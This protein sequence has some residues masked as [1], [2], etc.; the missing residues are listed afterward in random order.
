MQTTVA[1]Q[2]KE[3]NSNSPTPFHQPFTTTT[4]CSSVTQLPAE[5]TETMIRQVV[6]ALTQTMS[7]LTLSKLCNIS[8]VSCWPRQLPATTHILSSFVTLICVKSFDYLL[9]YRL[10]TPTCYYLATNIVDRSRWQEARQ[11]KVR[12]VWPMVYELYQI[13]WS[14]AIGDVL[15]G[16]RR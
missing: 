12:W 9:T 3:T 7:Q 11:E 4:T 2:T 5:W 13:I 10:C 8:Q 16:W 6:L 14:A 15:R 1:H